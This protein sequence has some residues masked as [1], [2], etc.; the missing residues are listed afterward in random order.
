MDCP[1]IPPLQANHA[2]VSVYCAHTRDQQVHPE[3]ASGQTPT[4]TELTDVCMCVCDFNLG[5]RLSAYLSS[6]EPRE[7]F[8]IFSWS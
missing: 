2:I 8:I 7:R 6:A 5:N 3:R 4:T 1:R